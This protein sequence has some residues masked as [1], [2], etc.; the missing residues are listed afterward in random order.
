[1]MPLVP[2]FVS[3]SEAN[4]DS[5]YLA[6]VALFKIVLRSTIDATNETGFLGRHP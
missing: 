6:M 5:S 1:M 2:V 3:G 4:G